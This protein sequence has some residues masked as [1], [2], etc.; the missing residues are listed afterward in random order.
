MEFVVLD[1]IVSDCDNR[2]IEEGQQSESREGGSRVV[3]V[4][5]IP[6]AIRAIA[7]GIERKI[8]VAPE[9]MMMKEKVIMV[10]RIK[11]VVGVKRIGKAVREPVIV[12]MKIGPETSVRRETS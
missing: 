1:P 11:V 7:I 2:V 9:V 6:W 5:P 3:N 8:D 4:R 12:T 10:K